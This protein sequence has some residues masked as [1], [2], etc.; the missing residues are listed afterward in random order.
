MNVSHLYR[1]VW[2]WHFYAGLL[3]I[4]LILILSVTGAIYLFKPQIELWE[5]RDWRGLTSTQTVSP[6]QQVQAALQA[7]P[8]S[9]FHAYRLPAAQSDAAMIHLAL[10]DGK[11]MR[12]VFVSPDGKVVG[13]LDPEARLMPL[14]QAIHGQLLLG[15]QGS[16]LVELAASWAIVMLV[17]GL[18]LWWPRGRTE[19]MAGILWPRLNRGRRVLLRD[20]HAVTGFWVAGLALVL[21]LTGLPWADVW[22]SGFRAVRQQMGWVQGRQEW[23]IGGK[24][25]APDANPLH[26][27]H[28]H[29]AMMSGRSSGHSHAAMQHTP[30]HHGPTGAHGMSLVSLN[31]IAARAKGEHLA[32]PVWVSPPGTPVPFR[33]TPE[34]RWTVRSDTQ[35]RPLG[36]SLAYDATTG[37]VLSRDS[38]ADKH[39]IDRV[40]GYGTAWHEGQLFGWVNQLIGLLTAIAL[41]TM[42]ITGFLMWRRR[43]PDDRLGAPVAPSQS[44]KGAGTLVIFAVFLL[45][46]PMFTLS[47]IVI[48]LLERLVL[49]RL[50]RLAHWLGT[51]IKA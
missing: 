7:V 39:V 17:T 42:A 24:A 46:L 16:W 9:S 26:A 12:D 1:T 43:K 37:A 14:V 6:E 49:P 8:G 36:A 13:Q 34:D 30:T 22:G 18:Y 19:G 21:L 51:P 38:F 31:E 48:T 41:F 45:L 3:V 32:Y 2:R 29:S 47:V 11:A 33:G 25:V 4:P 40:V 28:D 35:N 15:R 50:P 44:G 20:L 23:T 10:A 27:D 5:E